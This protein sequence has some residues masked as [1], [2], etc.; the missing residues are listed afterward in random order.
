MVE[1]VIIS[2]GQYLDVPS[3]VCTV[4]QLNRHWSD[5][6][7]SVE[8]W[9]FSSH[10]FVLGGE[11]DTRGIKRGLHTLRRIPNSSRSFEYL[12]EMNL[13]IRN[14]PPDSHFSPHC[15]DTISHLIQ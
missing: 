7:Y 11:D 13:D 4:R 5:I 12:A 2:V 10:E 9:K 8:L 6:S 15:G 14:I 1:D 3:I